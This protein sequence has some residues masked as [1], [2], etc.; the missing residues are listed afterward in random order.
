MTANCFVGCY[1]HAKSFLRKF[2]HV[3]LILGSSDNIGNDSVG[4]VRHVNKNNWI[5]GGKE[6]G[7]LQQQSGTFLN[8]TK[9][10]FYDR[11]NLL[12]Q[13]QPES[14]RTDSFQSFPR[15]DR[16]SH[17]YSKSNRIVSEYRFILP[18]QTDSIKTNQSR[19]STH[20]CEIVSNSGGKR[21]VSINGNCADFSTSTQREEQYN[22]YTQSRIHHQHH[23]QPERTKPIRG[24]ADWVSVAAA[25]SD[26]IVTNG[27]A[28]SYSSVKYPRRATNAAYQADDRI[29][30]EPHS[31]AAYRHTSESSKEFHQ[32]SIS[33]MFCEQ[34]LC[35]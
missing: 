15:P 23:V 28:S 21:T 18:S 34:L 19:N 12:H 14:V 35:Q 6:E 24:S 32:V 1:T 5:I 26:K 33:S 7:V 25:N 31:E 17:I 27:S 30:N 9:Q 11:N 20:G 8:N 16:R 3:N 2:L 4:N 10:G 22:L 13:S 29:L